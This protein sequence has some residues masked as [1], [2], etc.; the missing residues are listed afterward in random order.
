MSIYLIDYENVNLSGLNGIE[1]LSPMD[2]VYLFYGAN[3]GYIPFEKHIQIAKTP[4]E[5]TYLKVDRSG[6]NYLDFQLSTYSGYLV[7]MYNEQEYVIVSRDTGFDSIVNFWNQDLEGR[8]VHF[9]RREAI[10]APARPQPIARPQPATPAAQPAAGYVPTR[11]APQVP[12][13]PAAQSTGGEESGRSRSRRR[14]RGG[15]GGA[16]RTAAPIVEQALPMQVATEVAEPMPAAAE[17]VAEETEGPREAGELEAFAG[18]E[19]DGGVI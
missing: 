8:G 18:G 19:G 10:V 11:P 3:P 7:A 15:R 12:A 5:V 1:T 6:K 4:A 14:S 17:E 13:A 9:T 2:R 16:S